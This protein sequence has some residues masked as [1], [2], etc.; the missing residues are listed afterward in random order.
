MSATGTAIINFGA[1]PGSNEASAAVTGQAEITEAAKA[2][3]FFMADD[4]TPD[5]TAADHRWAPVFISLSCGAATAATGFTIHARST[6][7]MQGQWAVRWV[8][9]D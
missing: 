9:A 3:A 7:K 8:W 6:Q 4:T 5:H 1:Y 2:E